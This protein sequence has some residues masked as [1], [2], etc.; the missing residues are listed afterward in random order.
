MSQYALYQL[1][2]AAVCGLLVGGLLI[3]TVLAIRKDKAPPVMG[4]A[5]A[6]GTLNAVAFASGSLLAGEDAP[7]AAQVAIK[8]LRNAPT[9]LLVA[10]VCRA[11]V[12]HYGAVR[13]HTWIRVPFERAPGVIFGTFA[14]SAVLDFVMRPSVLEVSEPMPVAALAYNAL[15]LAPLAFYGA[16]CAVV[17]AGAALGRSAPAGGKSQRLQNAC[18]ALALG[19]SAALTVVTFSW[20][21]LRSTSPT[22]E[23]ASEAARMGWMQLSLIVLVVGSVF[24]GLACHW[25]EGGIERFTRRLLDE[26]GVV[27]DV[28]EMLAAAP[29][30]DKKLNV[31]YL[32]LRQSAAADFLDLPKE[33]RSRMEQ[34]FRAGAILAGGDVGYRDP[35]APSDGA[36]RLLAASRRWEG[37]RGHANRDEGVASAFIS[38]LPATERNAERISQSGQDLRESVS[39][40][41]ELAHEGRH[42]FSD[43]PEWAQLVCVA[44][45]DAGLLSPAPN[46]GEKV[47][48][49][50]RLAKYKVENY[51]DGFGGVPDL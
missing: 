45:T 8:Y 5:V 12:R 37:A 42:D 4:V 16:L 25:R 47:S 38:P 7:T 24:V 3:V 14:L 28:T 9:A 20:Y 19:G 18:G 49:T 21:V 22:P 35:N 41:L 27:A 40:A 39:L 17:F 13:N 34:S 2:V 29:L 15:M 43:R 11:Q 32:C 23:L 50:Y 44:L 48:Q 30:V 31:P 1:E 51:R 6:L 46:I 33:E 10:Y 36:R 26:L